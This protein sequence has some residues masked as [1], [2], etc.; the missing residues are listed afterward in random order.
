MNWK[1]DILKII[2]KV[3]FPKQ[4]LEDLRT[5]D[6]LEY[7]ENR[8]L[9]LS[10]NVC[11]DISKEKDNLKLESIIISYF[12]QN[13]GLCKQ[14]IEELIKYIDTNKLFSKLE[15]CGIVSSKINYICD[16]FDM[17][18]IEH[19]NYGNIDETI[20]DIDGFF[21]NRLYNKKQA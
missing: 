13:K 20:Y 12:Y 17:I 2:K 19:S 18:H 8:L 4:T 5:M 21:G 3:F 9:L 11:I 6:M 7:N 14:F 15:I 10:Q 16:K 1:N